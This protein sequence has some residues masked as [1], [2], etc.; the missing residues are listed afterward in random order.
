MGIFDIFKKNKD[1]ANDSENSSTSYLENYFKSK[2]KVDMTKISYSTNDIARIE[3]NC[4]IIE[5]MGLSSYKELKLVPVDSIV[6]IEDKQ[7]LALRL[8]FDFFVGRKAI[9]RLNNRGD[10]DDADV[11]M[12]GVKYAPDFNQLAS[13]LSA[14]SKGEI[15]EDQLGDLVGLGE[16]AVVLAW[17]LGFTDKPTEDKLTLGSDL[18]SIFEKCHNTRDLIDASTLRSKEEIMEYADYVS[19]LDFNCMEL[20]LTKKDPHSIKG[21]DFDCIREHKTAIDQVTS[22]SIDSFLASR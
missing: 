4:E 8:I 11:M 1:S 19:R 14:I 17:V 3:K 10:V 7:E 13:T 18:V 12:L 5:K 15:G 9:N 6:T 20:A 22:F 2:L 21:L 16:Q